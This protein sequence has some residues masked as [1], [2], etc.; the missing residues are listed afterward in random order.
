MTDMETTKS[1]AVS[2]TSCLQLLEAV[3]HELDEGRRSS[4]ISAELI[5]QHWT[6]SAATQFCELA[7]TIRREMKSLPESRSSCAQR[8]FEGM[9]AAGS[10]IGFGAFGGIVM[11]MLGN[12]LRPMAIYALLPVLYGVVEL[13]SG[14][15][16]WW[17]HRDFMKQ[18]VATESTRIRKG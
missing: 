17:P 5:H 10:W 8:G 13:I 9:Q 15:L 3:I 12:N 14:F 2:D 16:L 4:D 6:K 1:A 18:E 11:Y 7:A